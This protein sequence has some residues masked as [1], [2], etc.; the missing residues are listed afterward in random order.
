M[1]FLKGIIVSSRGVGANEVGRLLLERPQKVLEGK[2]FPRTGA[3]EYP[4]GVTAESEST[5]PIKG[6]LQP[7]G[8]AK[9]T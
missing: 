1:Y 6:R 4:Q 2:N 5:K 8:S 3:N 9:Q 7:L